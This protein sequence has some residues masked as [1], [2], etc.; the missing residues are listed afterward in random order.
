LSLIRLHRSRLEASREPKVAN[1]Q[2][3][4]GVDEQIS[5]LEIAMQDIGRV[6]VLLI[7]D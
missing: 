7:S 1:L 5:R 4:I 3:A 2:L 6:D